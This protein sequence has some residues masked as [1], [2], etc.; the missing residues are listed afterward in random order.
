MSIRLDDVEES[1]TLKL[2]DLTNE[3]KKQGKDILGFNL[4]EPDFDT[5]PH[6]VAAAKKAL[7]TG[8]THYAPSAG[9]PELREAIA[10]KL[11]KD[12]G[13]DVNSKNILV[14]PGRQ[15]GDLR[16]L[17]QPDQQG[18]R[19]NS[20][21]AVLGLLRCLHQDERRQNRLGQDERGR[22]SLC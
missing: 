4:G 8:K 10:Q 6:I 9:I 3:L 17:L 5:P 16:G 1:A 12:N 19:G 11:K 14:T 13:L 22:F 20:F 15:T 21:R 2:A 7:D 18:R